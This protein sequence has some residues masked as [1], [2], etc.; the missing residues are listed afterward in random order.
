MLYGSLSASDGRWDWALS[1]VDETEA[2]RDIAAEKF[3]DCYGGYDNGLYRTDILY[4]DNNSV[5]DGFGTGEC[6]ISLPE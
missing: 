2:V 6:Y 5:T 4:T 3:P 1:A